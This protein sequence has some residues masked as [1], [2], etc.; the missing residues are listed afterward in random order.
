MQG[1][2]ATTAQLAHELRETLG[3]V[4]RRLRAEPGP[5]IPQLAVLSRLVD[6]SSSR[7]S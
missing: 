7:P 1:T 2:Q 4:L 3:R 6:P 5:P